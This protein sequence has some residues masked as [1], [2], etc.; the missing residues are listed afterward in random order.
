MNEDDELLARAVKLST[1]KAE[2][3]NVL[4]MIKEENED[5]GAVRQKCVEI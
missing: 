3:A 4:E 2:Q 5:E 1:K